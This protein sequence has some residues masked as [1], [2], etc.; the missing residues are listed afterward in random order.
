MGFCVDDDRLPA[1]S[2][3][4]RRR[5]K[6]YVSVMD[7][8]RM[9]GGGK[10]MVMAVEAG[11]TV[12]SVMEEARRRRRYPLAMQELRVSDAGSPRYLER[13]MDKLDA[14]LADYD[15][16]EDSQINLYMN[17]EFALQA[18][19]E[20]RGVVNKA[21]EIAAPGEQQQLTDDQK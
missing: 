19:R 12:A 20:A 4:G 5:E 8:I 14:T 13:Q 2:S 6:M 3:V 15:V 17:M 10:E 11:D 9:D 16:K 18:D 1:P 21:K 7:H